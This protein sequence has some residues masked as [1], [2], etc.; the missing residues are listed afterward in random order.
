MLK[1]LSIENFRCIPSATLELHSRGTGIV[2]PNG[3]G[4]T[5]LLEAVYFLAHGRSFRTSQRAKLVGPVAPFVRVV[6]ALSEEGRTV[7]AG[8]EYSQS[9][10]EARLG[11]ANVSSMSAIAERLP[12]QIIDPGV[13]RLVEEGSA[14]RRQLLDWGVFHVEHGFLGPWRR[15]QRALKQRNAALRVSPGQ[16]R[17]WDHELDTCAREIHELRRR[18]VTELAPAFAQLATELVGRPCELGYQPGWDH[19]RTLLSALD[20]TWLRDQRVKT[21]TVGAHRADLIFRV[22]GE[23]ARDR[24]S[25]GQQKLIASSLVLAQLIL[26]APRIPHRPCLLLDDPAAELDVDSLGKILA[27]IERIPAQL[28]VTSLSPAGLRGIEIGAMFHVEQGRFTAML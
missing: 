17:A 20:E 4:K 11:G 10:T 13:H 19:E 12:V 3:A 9:R 8:V 15:Y 7:T 21:T 25:R 24:I 23:V 1:S 5:S 18:Y 26:A 2:G 22:D 16:A 27:V 6:G 28:I 14:R